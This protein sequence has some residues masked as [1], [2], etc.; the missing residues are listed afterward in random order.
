MQKNPLL[1]AGMVIAVLGFLAFALGGF[2][3]TQRETKLQV[4]DL[5]VTAETQRN[6]PIPPIVSIGAIVIGVVLIGAAV[7]RNR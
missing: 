7:M 1:I 6:F 3:I 5:K 4:G 2:S